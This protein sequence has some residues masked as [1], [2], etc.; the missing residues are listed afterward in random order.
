M[1]L[2]DY[3]L[4]TAPIAVELDTVG[5]QRDENTVNQWNNYYSQV[6]IEFQEILQENRYAILQSYFGIPSSK[7]ILFRLFIAE[8]AER[9]HVLAKLYELPML[10]PIYYKKL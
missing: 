4:C 10:T 7:R 2:Q 8:A 6:V 9:I 3:N 1:F 5:D